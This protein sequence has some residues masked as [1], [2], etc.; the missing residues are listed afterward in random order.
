M[1]SGGNRNRIYNG[2]TWLKSSSS[3][4]AVNQ[5]RGSRRGNLPVV[6][7]SSKTDIRCSTDKQF[8]KPTDTSC[9]VPSGSSI[10]ATS[11]TTDQFQRCHR[12]RMHQTFRRAQHSSTQFGLLKCAHAVSF[13]TNEPHHRHCNL[14]GLTPGTIDTTWAWIHSAYQRHPQ[15]DFQ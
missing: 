2:S 3:R 9:Q 13:L 5:I 11:R 14:N 8:T 7:K 4:M 15:S 12:C 10:S 6:L 1:K